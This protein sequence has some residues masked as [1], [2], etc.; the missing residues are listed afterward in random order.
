[1]MS[2]DG[3]FTISLSGGLASI[4]DCPAI[5][6][7]LRG[8]APTLR[9]IPKNVVWILNRQSETTLRFQ[10]GNHAGAN[11]PAQYDGRLMQR[12]WH[13]NIRYFLANTPNPFCKSPFFGLVI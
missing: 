11:T 13:R 7:V 4:Y 1:M 9:C 3:T 10:N 2:V 12:S 6:I 8:N 5:L